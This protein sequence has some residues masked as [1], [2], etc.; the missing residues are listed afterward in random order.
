MALPERIA[1]Q[2][3]EVTDTVDLLTERLKRQLKTE[4]P[5]EHLRNALSCVDGLRRE[6][7]AMLDAE[8]LAALLIYI[9]GAEGR[10]GKALAQLEK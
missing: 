7:R 2:G 6:A 8:Q 5:V 1:T 9:D 10:I 3:R 4:S